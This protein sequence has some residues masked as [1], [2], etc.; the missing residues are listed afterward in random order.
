MDFDDPHECRMDG[1]RYPNGTD[2]V[3]E[4]RLVDCV[5]GKWEEVILTSGI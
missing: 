4:G 2:I 3:A 5:D 1:R